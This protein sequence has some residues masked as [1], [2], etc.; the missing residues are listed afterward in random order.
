ME[1]NKEMMVN[2]CGILMFC[3]K[4]I[5]SVEFGNHFSVQCIK[6]DDLFFKDKIRD[7]T[8]DIN[9]DYY[10]SRIL[11]NNSVY[12]MCIQKDDI[13]ALSGS[14]L[15]QEKVELEKSAYMECSD[16]YLN[17]RIN[18]LRLFKSGNIGLKNIFYAFICKQGINKSID[19][20][21][22]LVL[23]RNIVDGRM[24]TLTE[25]EVSLCNQWLADYSG[26]VY[27]LLKDSIEKFSWGMEQIDSATGFEQYTTAL[28][29]TLLPHNAN[30][31]KQMLANRVAVLLGDTPSDIRTIHQK[32]LDFYKYRSVSLHE[33]DNSKISTVEL[34]ELENITRNVLKLILKRC[35]VEYD[36]KPSITWKKIKIIITNELTS[37]VR[38]EQA[39]KNLP[40]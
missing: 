38:S 21:D 34:R 31:K 13:Y 5:S 14:L 35:K 1:I 10:D 23:T 20:R 40:D 36:K 24:F 30:R 4:S 3:D 37:M 11:E 7:G 27:A 18:L 12:F 16:K 2:I 32:M 19:K 15:N 6:L 17:E 26:P 22:R 25:K 9:I 33:G 28:E 39:A 29:M 8:G